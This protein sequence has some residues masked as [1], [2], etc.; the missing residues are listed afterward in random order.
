LS[1]N[2]GNTGLKQSIGFT[3]TGYPGKERIEK[4]QIDFF[5]RFGER[6]NPGDRI[7]SGCLYGR[8]QTEAAVSVYGSS[9]KP[10]KE[11]KGHH[12]GLK[13]ISTQL[14]FPVCS[15]DGRASRPSPSPGLI[16]N[17]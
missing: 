6:I 12:S 5:A 11:L 16:S 2:R 14:I 4:E 9:E 13:C 17:R 7:F 15:S 10:L 8:R 3:I 1:Y